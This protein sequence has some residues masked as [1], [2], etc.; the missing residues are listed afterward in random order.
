M[1]SP[2]SPVSPDVVRKVAALARL[3]VPEPELPLW[4]EQ[5]G[6]I[7]SYIDQ[8]KGLPEGGVGGSVQAAATPLREDEPAACDGLP[9]L[10]QNARLLHDHG[11]VP[12]VVGAAAAETGHPPDASAP[13]PP[14]AK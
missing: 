13:A 3:S 14:A 12:R 6:R 11:W 10:Q 2:P 5:L 1:A 9:A 8:L 4:T 7:V